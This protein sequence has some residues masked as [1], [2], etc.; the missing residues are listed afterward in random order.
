MHSFFD[1]RNPSALLFPSEPIGAKV[2]KIKGKNSCCFGCFSKSGSL[3]GGHL[4]RK[5][6]KAMLSALRRIRTS[7]HSFCA[8]PSPGRF[9]RLHFPCYSTMGNDNSTPL[10]S[11]EKLQATNCRIVVV[12]PKNGDDCLLELVNLPP[13]A[14]ILATGRN[15]E[16]LRSEGN[17]F[18]EVSLHVVCPLMEP[19]SD[20]QPPKRKNKRTNKQTKFRERMCVWV[21]TSLSCSCN[22]ETYRS[23]SSR[24]QIE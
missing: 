21:H 10:N 22:I 16:E 15:L 18:T 20:R 2:Q 8:R 3:G 14:R 13:E 17:L 24:K 19:E 4:G 7:A 1:R 5:R 6:E 11:L 12:G 9:S 23:G